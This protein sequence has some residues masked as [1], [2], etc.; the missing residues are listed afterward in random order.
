MRQLFSSYSAGIQLALNPRE[1]VVSLAALT[2]YLKYAARFCPHQSRRNGIDSARAHRD[3][4][5]LPE[6]SIH[7]ISL[8]PLQ[9]RM[10][11][12]SRRQMPYRFVMPCAITY[13]QGD[14]YVSRVHKIR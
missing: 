14:Y 8:G 6:G 3:R 5:V 1:W 7:R 12:I 11:G 10:Q 2:I 13:L 4:D 9:I